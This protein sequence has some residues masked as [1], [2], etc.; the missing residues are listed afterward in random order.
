MSEE[1]RPFPHQS[2][3][4]VTEGRAKSS[5]GGSNPN[6]QT[7]RNLGDRQGHGSRVKSSVSS[8]VAD[9]QTAQREREEEEQLPRPDAITLILQVDPETFDLDDLRTS[10]IEILSELEDG[11]II[12]ASADADLTEFQKKID[13]FLNSQRGGN[14]VAKV[15]NVL[16]RQQRTEF[17][18]SEELLAKWGQIRDEQVYVV[19]V[20]VSCLGA[21][22]KLTPHPDQREYKSAENYARAIN[23]WIANRDVTYQE[24]DDLASD[25]QQRLIEF[26]EA[27]RGEFLSSFEDGITPKFSKC[28]DSFSCLIQISGK[29]LKDLVFNFPYLFEV[30]ERDEVFDLTAPLETPIDSIEPI[31]TF[32]LTP[33]N[34]A[35]PRVCVI[36]SGIQENHPSL[37]NAIDIEYSRSWVPSEIDLTADLVNGGGHGTRVAGAILYPNTVSRTGRYEAVCWIQN[38]RVLD[39]NNRLPQKLYPPDLLKDIVEF[40]QSQTGTRI[41]NHS[42]AGYFPCRR[43]YMSTWATAIDRL[44]YE[45]DILFIVAAGNIP[46]N[47]HPSRIRLSIQSHLAEGRSYPDYL[48]ENSCRIANPAQSLQALTVGSVNRDSYNDPDW[49][50]LG[51]QDEPS[52]FSC[53]GFGIWDSV[54]PDVV[55]YGGDLI[56]DNNSP[57]TLKCSPN[58]PELVRST[59]SS[60]TAPLIAADN[61]GTSFAAPKV[62]HIVAQLAAEYPDASSLLYRALIVQ[63]ARWPAWAESS[64]NEEKLQVL[65]RIGYGIPN[66]ER[67]VGNTPHRITF[68]TQADERIQARSARIYQVKMPERLRSPGN[69]YRILVEITLSYKAQPRRTRR[70]RRKYLS[71]WLDWEC[72]KL[73]ESPERFK[74][75]ILAEYNAP[76]DTEKGTDLFTW[77]I[78][79]EKRNLTIKDASRSLGTLQ[80]DWAILNSYDL[81]EAFCIAVV[82]HEG[83]NNDPYAEVPFTLAVSFEAIGADIPLYIDVTEAQIPVE[84]EA[85]VEAEI[86][87]EVEVE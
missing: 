77:T 61:Y 47:H 63:S 18:L 81:R 7:A 62:T 28:P 22:T 30:A 26:V 73:G 82:G 44:S 84:S 85:T 46:L 58:S 56:I 9:W 42:I 43:R 52:A 35:A 13:L 31:T 57:P 54:K 65:R 70:H 55:E 69:E 32:E 51:E 10:G 83:W 2:L 74:E 78:G 60:S 64:T 67:T 41:F 16:D 59:L 87:V 23:T 49:S 66:L 86:E 11:F 27:H 40:Y 71:T 80:K 1:V 3:R 75:R 21:T 6:S 20:G 5:G 8:A 25:R 15:L 4:F 79:K 72:S 45:N 36:D 53:S 68:I 50:S 19:E 33:P 48:E 37:A 24:W 76:D 12:G 39:Q 17:I 14:V 34:P 29:G 38:A